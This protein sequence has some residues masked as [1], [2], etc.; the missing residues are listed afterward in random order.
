M[1]ALL[2]AAGLAAPAVEGVEMKICYAIERQA[3]KIMSLRQRGLSLAEFMSDIDKSKNK[4]LGRIKPMVIAAYSVPRYETAGMIAKAIDDFK[5]E[6]FLACIKS[7]DDKP[8]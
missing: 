3:E 2:L 6:R 5:D 7:I 8:L 1:I 4:K